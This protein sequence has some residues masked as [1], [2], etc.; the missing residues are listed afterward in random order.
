MISLENSLFLLLA[1]GQVGEIAR[2]G[3]DRSGRRSI[4]EEERREEIGQEARNGPQ[5]SEILLAGGV[6][7]QAKASKIGG[8]RKFYQ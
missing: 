6:R 1:A 2:R 8:E 4:L 3:R 5:G 7:D